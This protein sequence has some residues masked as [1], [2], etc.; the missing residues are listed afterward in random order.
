MQCHGME[1]LQTSAVLAKQGAAHT[2]GVYRRTLHHFI[3]HTMMCPMCEHEQEQLLHEW[4]LHSPETP[5]H[6]KLPQSFRG[7]L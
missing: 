3:I 2:S 5:L 1:L 4:R 6:C 7:V